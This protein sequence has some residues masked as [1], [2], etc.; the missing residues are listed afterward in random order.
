[1]L[2]SGRREKGVMR[3]KRIARQSESKQDD[4]RHL[5]TYKPDGTEAKENSKKA[6]STVWRTR[7]YFFDEF[8]LF[9]SGSSFQSR[10]NHSFEVKGFC[11]LSN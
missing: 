10:M 8:S 4:I 7:L 6:Q 11:V 5:L 1:M 2:G 3:G 9:R